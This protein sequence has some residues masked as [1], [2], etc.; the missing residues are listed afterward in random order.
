MPGPLSFTIKAHESSF[1]INCIFTKECV[2]LLS[3]YL[4]ALLKRLIKIIFS[5]C[6][7]LFIVTSFSTS[8]KIS[9]RSDPGKYFNSYIIWLANLNRFIASILIICLAFLEY[10]IKLF[11]TSSCFFMQSSI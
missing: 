7:S 8:L 2:F 11:M 4:M 10:C 3:L 6:L 5:L 9:I 1:A